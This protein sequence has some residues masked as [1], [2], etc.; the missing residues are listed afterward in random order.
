MGLTLKTSKC[1]EKTMTHTG[2]RTALDELIHL[3]DL[4]QTGKNHFLG[5]S[6]D[7]GFGNLFG[8][9]VVAQSLSAACRTISDDF[10][11]NSLHGYF[12]EAGDVK[13]PIVYTVDPVR[14]GTTFS[15]RQVVASQNK[16]SMF[17][18]LVSFQKPETGMEY[19]SDMPDVPG[20]ETLM[21]ETQ[22]ARNYARDLPSRILDKLMQQRPIE[23]RPV[24]PVH[25]FDPV[26]MPPEKYIWF[27]ATS[28]VPDDP[29]LHRLLLAYA[30]DFHM[31]GTILYPHGKTY[32]L[33]G[34]QVASLDH[35][36]WYYREF[37]IDDWLLHVIKTPAS[38][39]GRGLAAGSVFTRDG[40]LVAGTAQEGLIRSQNP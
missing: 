38:A 9:L 32:W 27:R 40:R 30:S 11:V 19:Q 35:A 20:P 12:I 25:Y 31:T 21:T 7:M 6:Q 39:G 29:H 14:N 37:K 1:K 3:L 17:I 36:L 33:P 23:I 24:N 13:T 34:M 28:A 8:G 15:T 26:P 16:K 10:C 5:Q 18:M 4:E 22:L 2:T